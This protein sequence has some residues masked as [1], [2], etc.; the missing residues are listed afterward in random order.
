MM[1]A[2][3]RAIQ[4]QRFG[5]R[6]SPFYLSRQQRGFASVNTQDVKG[7]TVIDHHYEY[8]NIHGLTLIAADSNQRPRRR[9]WR[10]RPP[11]RCRPH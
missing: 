10:R 7:L 3:A 6:N 5:A 9:S 4:R 1:R 2:F 11:R 8:E